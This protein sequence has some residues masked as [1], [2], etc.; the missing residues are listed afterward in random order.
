VVGQSRIVACP[1]QDVR[2]GR[3]DP[4]AA[5]SEVTLRQL[6]ARAYPFH[7]LVW[8]SV[9]MPRTTAMARR[10]SYFETLEMRNRCGLMQCVAV[11]S[12][13]IAQMGCSSLGNPTLASNATH[14]RIPANAVNYSL[15]EQSPAT[16]TRARS[17]RSETLTGLYSPAGD[18]VSPDS[19]TR[20]VSSHGPPRMRTECPHGTPCCKDACCV[21]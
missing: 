9:G 21:N 1:C 19:S 11:A 6:E 14:P 3:E 12:V 8:N 4:V 20:L 2:R 7:P 5:G 13:A 18:S 17:E 16:P 10:P 15:A